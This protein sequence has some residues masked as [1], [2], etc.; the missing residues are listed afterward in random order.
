MFPIESHFDVQREYDSSTGE[1]SNVIS[2]NTSDRP[3]YER[4]YMRV[5]WDEN[6]ILDPWWEYEGYDLTIGRNGENKGDIAA[7]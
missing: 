4:S 3:W 6:P 2:E 5:K 7:T 1:Q